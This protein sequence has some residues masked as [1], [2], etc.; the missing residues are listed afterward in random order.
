[1]EPVVAWSGF[2]ATR[3]CPDV[4]AGVTLAALAVPEVLGYARIAGMPV[5][6]GHFAGCVADGRYADWTSSVTDAASRAGGTGTSTV[7]ING[8]L[9]EN[10]DA[11]LRQRVACRGAQGA[12]GG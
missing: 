10:T 11:T 1:V 12:G 3:C 2:G 8:Q 4:L 9:I 7:L 5:A 6:T